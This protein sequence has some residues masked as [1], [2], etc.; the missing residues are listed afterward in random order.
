M[1]F[2]KLLF[3]GMGLFT[4]STAFGYNNIVCKKTLSY[5]PAPYKTTLTINFSNVSRYPEGGSSRVDHFLVTREINHTDWGILSQSNRTSYA[6]YSCQSHDGLFSV[7]CEQVES[8][9]K[10]ARVPSEE[11]SEELEMY[12]VTLNPGMVRRE[13]PYK[14]EDTFALSECKFE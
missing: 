6:F 4:C 5:G 9:A 10:I 2:K 1:K 12:K 11:G 8:Q 13:S 3:A 7:S 14:A